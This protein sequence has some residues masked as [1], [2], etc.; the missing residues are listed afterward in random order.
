MNPKGTIAG[1]G[2]SF[3]AKDEDEIFN[4]NA[5]GMTSKKEVSA[6]DTEFSFRRNNNG[7][8]QADSNEIIKSN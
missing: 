4:T 5:L 6:R 7:I 2:Y 1:A 3:F 8:F